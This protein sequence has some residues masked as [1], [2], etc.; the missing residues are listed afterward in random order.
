MGHDG[1]P[2][3]LM[4]MNKRILKCALGMLGTAMIWGGAAPA[5][6]A[7]ITLDGAGYYALG[8]KTRYFKSGVRQRGRY[9]NLGTDY[10]RRGRI[11]MRWVT[12]NTPRRTGG[13][14]F[15]LWAMQYYGAESGIVLMTTS[16]G[17]LPGKSFLKRPERNGY[18]V[19]LDRRRFPELNLWE[20][21]KAGWKWR[22]S[23]RFGRRDWL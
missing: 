14:S 23:L 13:L 17:R 4:M 1:E 2:G 8:S 22:D 12:N 7:R 18:A 9:S 19:S 6:A 16:L 20:Y 3:T 15:E 11:G 21:T 5:E 10:Y